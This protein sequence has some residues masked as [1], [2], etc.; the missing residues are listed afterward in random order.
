MLSRAGERDP[1]LKG[2]L[3]L[4]G[5]PQISHEIL[6]YLA[7]HP[8]ARDT[9]EG[10]VQWWLLDRKIRY[11]TGLVRE[12]LTELVDKGLILENTDRDSRAH[13]RINR[14]RLNEILAFLGQS[15]GALE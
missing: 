13:Y 12:A 3:C 11:Q 1:L 5:K 9:L 2:D 10:V 6:A 15:K 7:E 14:D 4:N 8:D